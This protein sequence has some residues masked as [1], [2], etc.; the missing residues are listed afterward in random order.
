M[1]VW[2]NPSYFMNYDIY[3]KKEMISHFYLIIVDIV[4]KAYIILSEWILFIKHL[5]KNVIDNFCLMVIPLKNVYKDWL[6]EKK[7]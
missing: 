5:N 1:E 6:K 4:W 7:V 3:A 2:P